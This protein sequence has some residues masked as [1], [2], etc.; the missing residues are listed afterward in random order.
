MVDTRQSIESRNALA[1]GEDY[2]LSA[3]IE[4]DESIVNLWSAEPVVSGSILSLEDDE[5]FLQ[6]TT[7]QFVEAE[8]EEEIASDRLLSDLL[9]EPESDDKN[10]DDFR[11]D[12]NYQESY[13]FDGHDDFYDSDNEEEEDI[14]E[15]PSSSDGRTRLGDEARTE[16]E[17]TEREQEEVDF[18][19]DIPAEVRINVV[20]PVVFKLVVTC[21]IP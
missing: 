18:L 21:L 9:E 17:E 3:L 10:F 20:L 6:R 16:T 19:A 4:P 13:R 2:G 12:E 15:S 7:G 1:G 5:E 11:V 8:A 14:C